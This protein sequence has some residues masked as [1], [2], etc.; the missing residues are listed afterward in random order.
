MSVPAICPGCNTSYQLADTMRGKKVRCKS[1]SEVFVVHGKT[2]TPDRDE[3]EERIQASPRPAERV[4]RD[5][6]DEDMERPPLRRRPLKK[7][8]NGA[9]LPLLIVACIVLGVLALGLG[10]VAV[11]ALTR[12]RQPQPAPVAAN[13]NQPAPVP[14]PAQAPA[15][16][17]NQPGVP[18]L[19]VPLVPNPVLA[20][21]PLIAELT[22]GNISGFGAQMQ[23]TANY[24]FTSGNPGGRRIFLF[25]K[26][27]K[28]MGFLQKQN[29]YVAELR[30]IGNQTQGTIRAAGMTFGIEHGP[31]EMWL[32]EGDPGFGPLV[33][34]KD[35]RKISNVVTVAGKQPG[36]PGMPGMPGRPPFGPP[37]MGP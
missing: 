9:V 4:A 34:E 1:C 25:I 10:G 13:S 20:Q 29:Y 19:A 24:R 12:S 23:V 6:E 14:Q 3:V 17:Q 33:A 16:P 5:E 21:G 28:A 18:P 26:A 32:G 22:N 27:T 2:L 11:W 36:I 7:R 35:L 15:P 8:S 31:F 30:S 37:R